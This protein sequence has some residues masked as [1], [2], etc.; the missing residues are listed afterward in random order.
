[1]RSDIVDTGDGVGRS[2][3]NSGS[4]ANGTG[5]GREDDAIRKSGVAGEGAIAVNDGRHRDGID[6]GVAGEGGGVVSERG[7]L[8]SK[9]TDVAMELTDAALA[10]NTAGSDSQLEL[11]VALCGSSQG[12][13][14]GEIRSGKDGVRLDVESIPIHSI[15]GSVDGPSSRITV[16]Q[17]VGGLDL[18][19]VDPLASSAVEGVGDDRSTARSCVVVVGR[20]LIEHLGNG[21]GGGGTN[22]IRIGNALNEDVTAIVTLVPRGSDIGKAGKVVV[23]SRDA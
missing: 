18:V 19:V 20:R 8:L 16:G 12:V 10:R 7:Q 17:R 5:S 6:E 21:V 1:M 11:V 15:V 14:L 9:D 3:A 23:D 2:G 4:S 22:G 13:V